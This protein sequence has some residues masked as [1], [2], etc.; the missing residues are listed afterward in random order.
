MTGMVTMDKDEQRTYSLALEVLFNR[1]TIVEF[2][3]MIGKCYRQS[4]RILKKIQDK[5]MLGIKHGNLGRVPV[6]KIDSDLRVQVIQL[7]RTKYFDFN[8]THFREKLLEVEGVSVNRETLRKW[9][10]EVD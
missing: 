2:S 7:L 1:L 9:C 4:Q 3:L 10:H 5:Q 6:N 8:V